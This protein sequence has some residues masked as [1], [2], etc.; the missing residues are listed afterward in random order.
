MTEMGR[1]RSQSINC[2]RSVLCFPGFL[3]ASI[4][5]LSRLDC[6]LAAL[7]K[8]SLIILQ[9]THLSFLKEHAVFVRLHNMSTD[10]MQIGGPVG[11]N[12]NGFT[13][14]GQVDWVAF[15]KSVWNVSSSVLQR[16]ASAGV[17]PITFGAGLALASGFDLDRVG[18]KRIHSALEKAEGKWSYEKVLEFGFGV[19]SFVHVMADAQS[20][21]NCIALCS[22]LGE[23]HDVHAAAW[24]LDELWKINGYPQQFLP[25]HSQF[26]ALIRACSGLL[27]RTE[28]SPLA[29]RML[30]HTIDPRGLN[31]MADFEDLA[32]A[33]NGLFRI[34]KGEIARIT[35]TGST[36]CAFVASFA[37]W[38]LNL[39]VYVHTTAGTVLFQDVS[40][41][42][43]QVV[44]TYGQQS[45]AALLQVS[46]TTYILREVEDLLWRT[47]N[48]EQNLICIR[49]P[50]DGCLARVFGTAFSSLVKVPMIFGDYLGSVAR[51]YQA[52]ALGEKD[53]GNLSRETFLNFVEP[54]YGI[55][56]INSVTSIFPE[57]NRINGFFDEM[58]SALDVPLREALRTVERTTLD[59]EQLCQ[60]DRCSS[61]KNE[62][63]TACIVAL[64]FSIRDMVSTVSCVSRNDDILPTIRGMHLIHSR[65]RE[66]LQWQSQKWPSLTIPLGLY[67]DD[68]NQGEGEQYLFYT[69][70]FRKPD[71]LSHPIELFSGYSDHSRYTTKDSTDS[72]RQY[73]AATVNQ[74]L[75]YFLSS[76]RSLS[77]DAENARIVHIMPGHIQM[78]EKRFVSVY[79]TIGE[80]RDRLSPIQYDIVQE[81]DYAS[82]IQ[83]PRQHDIKL[84]LRGQ[85]KATDDDLVVFY[86]AMISGESAIVLD[87][88]R[89]TYSILRQS[90]IVTCEHSNCISR[91]LVPCAMVRQGWQVADTNDTKTWI[92]SRTGHICFIWPELGEIGR[93]MEVESLA[94][95]GANGCIAL[96]RDECISCCIMSLI[97]VQDAKLLC[98][99]VFHI[100]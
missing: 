93:C 51:V 65:I 19:R 77:S 21:I 22:A 64:A 18:K 91:P 32:K 41:E 35:V 26:T 80:K 50:W 39:K 58:Q 40:L 29:D 70:M 45:D 7:R 66:Y 56:F 48:L 79:D 59:F 46:K 68:I 15:A 88:A 84:E 30:G 62:K 13:Q 73:C 27:A 47:P 42:E 97:R 23:L 92:G 36:E 37:H 60:C 69:D 10:S 63:N 34:S 90:G 55:G 2:E 94:R 81:S 78:D 24:V 53:V 87:P 1:A 74:G 95:G 33:L 9:V 72:G 100:L 5:G 11:T 8:K 28:F 76:L 44:I 61:R 83:Q 25:S 96:R 6:L 99:K 67:V 75:C 20:G 17:Q 4:C 98:K 57:L 85:A 38:V 71:L 12:N 89:I 16:F 31:F 3:V 43:A 54:S 86:R 82:L 14:N 49:T 52:L